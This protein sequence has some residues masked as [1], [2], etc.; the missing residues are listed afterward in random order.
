MKKL[1][2]FIAICCFC[3]CTGDQTTEGKREDGKAGLIANEA[4]SLNGIPKSEASAMVAAFQDDR[5][6][7]A[8]RTSIWI[9]T[10]FFDVL[11]AA[12]KEVPEADGIRI[13]FAK[14]DGKNAV[15]M[16]LTSK[17]DRSAENRAIDIHHDEFLS[18][19]PLPRRDLLSYHYQDQPWGAGL[20]TD[21]L[22]CP[23]PC[24][25]DAHYV[26]CPTARQWA[27]NFTD[28]QQPDKME[29]INKKSIWYPLSVFDVIKGELENKEKANG[30]GF[31][32]YYIKN[33]CGNYGFLLV[34]TR[35]NDQGHL[36]D[37]ECRINKEML[38]GHDRGEECTPFCDG[39][40]LPLPDPDGKK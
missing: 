17:G 29:K 5:S 14:K 15:V 4:I 16:V 6:S 12:K 30:D 24:K 35:V 18:A 40:T 37:Y 27:K 25:G 7:S 3:S 9:S 22:Q 8:D 21:A 26:D 2:Y 19:I 11:D 10:D 36:D 1:F 28:S 39:V 34:P 31:R 13:Y 23:N 38:G 20:Y 32:I 33:D